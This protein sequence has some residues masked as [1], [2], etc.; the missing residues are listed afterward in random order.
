MAVLD[1]LKKAVSRLPEKEYA[2]FRNWFVERDWQ[3]WDRQIAADS[4]AGNLDF[5]VDEAIK[6]KQENKLTAL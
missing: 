3:Q 4:E 2:Q 6:A 5:L 1:E